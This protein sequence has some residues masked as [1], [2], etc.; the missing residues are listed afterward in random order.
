MRDCVRETGHRLAYI[1]ECLACS[2]QTHRRPSR[3]DRKSQNIHKSSVYT[4]EEPPFPPD[5][6]RRVNDKCGN[7]DYSTQWKTS[8]QVLQDGFLCTIQNKRGSKVK[9]ESYA[10]ATHGF[11]AHISHIIP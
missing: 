8:E 6:R 11:S 2:Q 9:L 4:W 7:I 1:A 3:V 10:V 5:T